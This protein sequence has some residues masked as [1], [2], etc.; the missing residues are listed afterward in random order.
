MIRRL[1]IIGSLSAI[2]LLLAGEEPARQ[3][4]QITKTEKVDFPPGGLLRF[5]NSIGDLTVEGWDSPEVEITTTKSA[6]NEVPASDRERASRELEKVSIAVERMGDEVVVTTTFPRHRVF[7]PQVPWS[8]GANFDLEYHVRAP[9]LARLAIRHDV[10][11]VHVDD[12]LGDINATLL[13]G[14]LLLHLP[15]DARYAIHAKCDYGNVN[16]DYPGEQKRKW[17]YMGFQRAVNDDPQA[18][19]TLDLKVGYGDIMILKTRIPKEPPS[20]IPAP[21]KPGL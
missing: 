1:T 12:V 10:G 7:P 5:E 16:S 15:Q 20:L 17:W 13:Q 2:G 11:E 19:H 9:R 3:K 21:S 8:S 4:V 14:E 6:K 18:P